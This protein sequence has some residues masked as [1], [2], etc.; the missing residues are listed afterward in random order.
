MLNQVI[1]FYMKHIRCLLYHLH[2]AQTHLVS[3]VSHWGLFEII[4]IEKW[5]R[6][7]G[8]YRMRIGSM[9]HISNICHDSVEWIYMIKHTRPQH[10]TI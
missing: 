3:I 10:E 2:P 6:Y 4:F 1:D 8:K 5:F 9:H 7:E